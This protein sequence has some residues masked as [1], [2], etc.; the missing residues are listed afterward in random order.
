MG[1]EAHT[2]RRNLWPMRLANKLVE[3]YFW[4]SLKKSQKVVLIWMN[5]NKGLI[6][7]PLA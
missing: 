7:I 3:S 4:K 6:Q 2:A 5:F 1:L